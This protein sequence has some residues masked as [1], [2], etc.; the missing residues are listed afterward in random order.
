MKECTGLYTYKGVS[1]IF[2]EYYQEWHINAPFFD[3]HQVSKLPNFKTISSA[4][5][6]IKD[7]EKFINNLKK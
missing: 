6:W 7:H 5:K 2:S 3:D 1:I 4:K